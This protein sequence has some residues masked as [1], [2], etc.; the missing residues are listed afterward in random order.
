[1]NLKDLIAVTGMSGV[2]RLAANRNNGLIVEELDSGKRKFAS[3]RK[4]Q[5][6]PLESI[7]IFTT[8]DSEEL[9]KVFQNMLDQYEDNPPI[10]P[11][12]KPDEL[13]EYFADVL[14]NFDR[15][16]VTTGDIKKVIK[17]F[18][19]LHERNLLTTDP[20]ASSEEEE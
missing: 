1:M 16:Q 19:F 9:A 2:F 7:A 10:N 6:T 8:E 14:P 15:D 20:E 4:H 17:W 3:A 18:N 5:F 12:S 11:N 13:R